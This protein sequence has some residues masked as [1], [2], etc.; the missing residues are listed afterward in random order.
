MSRREMRD[1]EEF[2]EFAR[3]RFLLLPPSSSVSHINSLTRRLLVVSHR[4]F[5]YAYTRSLVREL[6]LYQRQL[7]ILRSRY[8]FLMGEA[9]EE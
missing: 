2:N 3:E 4:R 7:A 6:L 1:F 5:E 9:M 8:Y